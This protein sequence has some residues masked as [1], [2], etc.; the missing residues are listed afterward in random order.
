MIDVLIRRQPCADTQTHTQEW[1]ISCEDKDKDQNYE[2]V[3]QDKPKIAGK[4]AEANKMQGR[5][6]PYQ[7]QRSC[8]L[9]F[10][11]F[12]PLSVSTQLRE[13][14]LI[15]HT[16]VIFLTLS[17]IQN[18]IGYL[19]VYHIISWYFQDLFISMLY[20]FFWLVSFCIT[21]PLFLLV[22]KT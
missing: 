12:S 9:S 8:A 19:S 11:A 1:R 13:T 5:I 3:N 20:L 4:L 16:D 17:L 10:S 15:T 21:V 2:T 18:L 22:C 14:V 7:F 6:F